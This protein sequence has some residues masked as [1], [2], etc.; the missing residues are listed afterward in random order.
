MAKLDRLPVF[1]CAFLL[2]ITAWSHDRAYAQSDLTPGIIGEDNRQPIDN[3][4]PPWTAIGQVNARGYR[5]LS[6]CTGTLVAPRV[7]LTAAHCVV[8]PFKKAP[9]PAKD[10]HFIA[11]VSR[12]K[13]IGHSVARCLKFPDGFHYSGPQRLLLTLPAQ[14]VAFESFKL[15]LA[16]IVLADDIPEAG[17]MKLLEHDVLKIGASL[18]HASYPI[19]RRYQLTGDTSCKAVWQDADVVATN[20]DTRTG[21][22][23]GPIL[24]E[25]NGAKKLAAVSVGVFEKSATIAVP[26]DRWPAIP[27]NAECP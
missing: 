17:V 18:V 2:V 20:C 13:F 4:N 12:D 11:G 14:R 26:L 15:D 5:M 22:S 19:D 23:G 1:S 7:V 6:F 21:S 8:D 27:L 24:I 3:S 9:F 10:I 25:E 16:L